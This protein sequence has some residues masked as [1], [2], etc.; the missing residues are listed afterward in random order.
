MYLNR[1]SSLQRANMN[2]AT[3]TMP[4]PRLKLVKV[5][6]WW[7]SFVLTTTLLHGPLLPTSVVAACSTGTRQPLVGRTYM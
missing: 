1:S 3:C 7:P 5:G 4:T 2:A 6:V